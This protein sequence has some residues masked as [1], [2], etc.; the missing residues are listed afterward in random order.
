[1]PPRGWGGGG[2]GGGGMASSAESI[3]ESGHSQRPLL[4]QYQME[5][6]RYEGA[7]TVRPDVLV[8]VRDAV[9]LTGAKC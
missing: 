4:G 6:S 2:G 1:M 7:A 9:G 5:S 8:I 3:A